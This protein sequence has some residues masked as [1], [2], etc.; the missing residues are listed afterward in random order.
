MPTKFSD[1]GVPQW[2][3]E[4]LNQRGI[5]EPFEIQEKTIKDGLEGKDIC[6]RAPTG[7]G[8]TLAFGI[9]LAAKTQASKPRKPQSLIL[10]PTREL[11]QQICNELRTFS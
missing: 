10:A 8:K 2:I 4:A 1:L 3:V 6:G 7:S 9:P 11:A 5:S